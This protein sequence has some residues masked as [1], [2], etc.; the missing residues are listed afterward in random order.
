MAFQTPITIKEALTKIN[1]RD[2]VLPA[3]QR[4]FVWKA[5]QIARLFDSLMRGFPI[6]SFLFW[7]VD[8]EHCHDYVF[9]D[10]IS[11]YHERN[12]R[13]LKRLQLTEKRDVT[14]ILDGQQRLTA[15][16]IGFFG[17]HAEK[18]PRRW[19]DNPS[20]YP[21]RYLYLNLGQPAEENELGLDY[22][23]RFLTK[24]RADELNIAITNPREIYWFPVKEIMSFDDEPDLFDFVQETGIKDSRFAFRT[25]ARLHKVAHSE[26]IIN[27]FQE[28]SQ[29]LDKVLNIFIRVNSAGEP[30]SY[31]D[32]LLSIATAQWN[33][34]EAREVIHGLVDELNATGQR[35]NFNKDLVLKAGLVLTDI[36][37]IAFR[38]TNFN[39]AN[40][41][42]LETNWN[43]IA[44]SLRLAVQLL[45]DFGF[46]D[47]TLTADS[48]V[49]PIAYYLHRR[50]V[51]DH[52]LTSLSAREDRERLR[53]WAVRSLIKSGIWGSGLDTLLLNLRN[54]IQEYGQFEF[55]AA[56][57]ESSMTRLGKSLRFEED[58]I[59]D[60][61][62]IK[63]QD[64]RT[65]PLLSLLYPGMNFRHEFHVDHIFPKSR[66]RRRQLATA[67][68]DVL[69][70]EDFITMSDELPNLQLMEGPI[71]ISK[72]DKMPL[73]WI[74]RSYPDATARDAYRLRHDLG[75]I[76]NDI[77]DFRAFFEARRGRIGNKLRSI[78]G[79][80]SV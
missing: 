46:S 36:P 74:E 5:D 42:T 44:S 73:E 9:Y 78:L 7:M 64:K 37:S 41:E 71:N 32:L 66:F 61:L 48:V 69:D 59:Q 62:G 12:A 57:L 11:D 13:H 68:V 34:I 67:G 19:V 17:S 47:R 49:I 50:N 45:S 58:E 27:Y 33:D 16:N 14:A 39:A 54:V 65:F 31:S 15:L 22:D 53:G 10:F 24:E 25:L 6:G 3:I 1:R 35:F 4:E 55:P 8:R 30:L 72:Q 80:S 60:L 38:V 79:V 70:I 51:T 63:Y 40:M 21:I 43:S 52:Y 2:Y 76:P 75:E 26:P 18:L 77:K 23:F 20:A 29:D 28:K 56:D